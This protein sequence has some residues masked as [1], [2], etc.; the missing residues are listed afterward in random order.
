ML[1]R[2][3]TMLLFRLLC[4]QPLGTLTYLGMT[5]RDREREREG[6]SV[7][8][9]SVWVAGLSFIVLQLNGYKE[10]P[11]VVRQ[12]EVYKHKI[13]SIFSTSSFTD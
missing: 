1:I 8:R 4:W 13:L 6:D 5:Q 9:L 3:V 2:F 7:R 11:P 10:T 12:N